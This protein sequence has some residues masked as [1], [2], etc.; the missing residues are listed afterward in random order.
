L[1]SRCSGFTPDPLA[2]KRL[3]LLERRLSGRGH[4]GDHRHLLDG[5]LDPLHPAEEEVLEVVRLG[6]LLLVA[7]DV[8]Q[9]RGDEARRPVRAGEDGAVLGF[10]RLPLR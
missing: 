8:R 1:P 5:L 4:L 2:R 3:A 9:R 6:V 10:E 7:V